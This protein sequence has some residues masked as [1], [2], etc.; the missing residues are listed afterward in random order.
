MNDVYYRIIGPSGIPVTNITLQPTSENGYIDSYEKA[1]AGPIQFDPAGY[2][3]LVYT[4]EEIGNYYIE[5][6]FPDLNFGNRREFDFFDITVV[7]EDNQPI[8]GKV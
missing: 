2:D 6:H 5:F 1:V 8:P 3:P 4:P 7:S